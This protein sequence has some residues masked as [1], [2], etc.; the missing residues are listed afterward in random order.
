MCMG[1]ASGYR[2]PKEKLT[3]ISCEKCGRSWQVTEAAA[4][5]YNEYYKG[6]CADCRSGK[7]KKRSLLKRYT[8]FDKIKDM[9][10]AELAIFIDTVTRSCTGNQ[11]CEGC[12][13]LLGWRKGT[14]CCDAN[15]IKKW[16]EREA[17][18]E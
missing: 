18:Q 6:I 7:G 10:V 3:V 9:S 16:L 8:N 15:T 13:I 5:H 12:P 2:E 11:D 17:E 4:K 1:L 14:P